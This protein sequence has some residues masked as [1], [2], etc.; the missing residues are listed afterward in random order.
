MINQTSFGFVVLSALLLSACSSD[1]TNDATEQLTWRALEG[2]EIATINDQVVSEDLLYAYLNKRGLQ[3]TEPAQREA[4]IRDLVDLILMAESATDQGR[5]TSSTLQARLALQ[6]LDALFAEA[7][8][9]FA[10]NSEISESEVAA[11]YQEQVKKT[12]EKEYHLR[13]ILVREEATALALAQRAQEGESFENLIAEYQPKVGPAN[14]GDIGWLNLAQVPDSFSVV[15]SMEPGAISPTPLSSEYGWHV[16][17]MVE[18]REFDPPSMEEV[19]QGIRDNLF[20]ERV[21]EH[22]ESLRAEATVEIEPA[23][24]MQQQPLG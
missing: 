20:R 19:S 7:M 13:H 8:S 3:I 6:E 14:A 1:D 2:E 15:A 4:A 16:V 11:A 22:V 10:Q 23:A 17:Q 5:V 24:G 21:Q 12:G 18:T 9:R